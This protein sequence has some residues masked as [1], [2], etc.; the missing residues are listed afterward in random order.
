MKLYLYDHTS[1]GDSEELLRAAAS[2]YCG[3]ADF[4]VARAAAAGGLDD[5]AFAVA[6]GPHGKPYFAAPPLRDRVHFSVSHSGAHWAALFHDAPVGL[7]IED[8]RI[9]EKM[10]A[11]RM[12]RI[13]ARFFTEDERAYLN[14]DR[15]DLRTRFFRVWTA[16]EA[17]VKYTGGGMSEGLLSFSALEPP[18]GVTIATFSPGPGLICSRCARGAHDLEVASAPRAAERMPAAPRGEPNEPKRPTAPKGERI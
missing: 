5:S 14:G 11:E 15:S 1:P 9:R 18:G 13:A 2:D 17:Y 7:D 8:L 10:T 6:R 3:G 12:E 16:K 4:A